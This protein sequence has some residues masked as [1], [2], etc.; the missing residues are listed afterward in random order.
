MQEAGLSPFHLPQTPTKYIY[1]IDLRNYVPVD[2]QPLTNH[3]LDLRSF[4]DVIGTD[5]RWFV[6][7][8]TPNYKSFHN[9]GKPRA[10][11]LFLN[12]RDATFHED[13][14]VALIL[15]TTFLRITSCLFLAFGHIFLLPRVSGRW[16]LA[17][18]CAVLQVTDSILVA[19]KDIKNT[20]LF[21]SSKP[22]APKK[23]R[24]Q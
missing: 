3:I 6:Y 19:S 10:P 21:L 8:N 22:K 11:L 5:F 4:N 18:L 13:L 23:V 17:M 24:V 14:V 2:A 16:S 1:S 20:C 12:K 7:K 9:N 15:R